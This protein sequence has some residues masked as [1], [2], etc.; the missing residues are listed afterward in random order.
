MTTTSV[1][2]KPQ[3]R[4]VLRWLLSFAGFPLGGL[5]AMILV[6]P[7]DSTAAALLGGLL[8]GAVLGVVQ[9]WALRLD[10]V[11]AVRWIAATAVGSG[12]GLA[13]GATLVGFGTALPQL[14]VQ[15]AVGGALVGVTQAVV[16]YR[17]TGAAAAV[18]PVY[19][20]LAWALGWTVTASIGVQ[21]AEQ[22]TVF[23]SAGALVVAA[24]TSVLPLALQRTTTR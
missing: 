5:A 20:A 24:L 11:Q 6:G 10:R 9:A 1:R 21:V 23:G 7:I 12:T 22:F 3:T 2:T 16:L 8:T 13:V 14:A 18:W 19:L 4:S 17:R 15:G